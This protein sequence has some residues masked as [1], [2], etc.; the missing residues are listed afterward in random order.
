MDLKYIYHY[1]LKQISIVL[2]TFVVAFVLVD[3]RETV[4]WANYVRDYVLEIKA[5]YVK[6]REAVGIRK[7]GKEIGERDT[8]RR[9]ERGKG[10]LR[11]RS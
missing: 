3:T 1:T 2:H 6:Y 4:S 10:G 11:K 7:G 9:L 5:K 8:K